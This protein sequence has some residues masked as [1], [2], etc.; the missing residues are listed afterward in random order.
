MAASCSRPRSVAE[1]SR[2]C[3]TDDSDVIAEV[4]FD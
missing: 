1:D 4:L 3:G 2:V